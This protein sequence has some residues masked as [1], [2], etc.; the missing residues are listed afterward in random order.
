MITNSGIRKLSDPARCAVQLG[1]PLQRVFCA[2][3]HAAVEPRCL[4]GSLQPISV[5]IGVGR[6]LSGRRYLI[7]QKTGFT[8]GFGCFGLGP[9]RTNQ[10]LAADPHGKKKAIDSKPR[11]HL[12]FFFFCTQ[13][14][15][16]MTG[17]TAA[18]RR[19]LPSASSHV[20]MPGR[21][22]ASSVFGE[23]PGQDWPS[24]ILDPGGSHRGRRSQ[25]FTSN[26]PGDYCGSLCAN[27]DYSAGTAARAALLARLLPLDCSHCHALPSLLFTSRLCQLSP[28]VEAPRESGSTTVPSHF[29][30]HFSASHY[31]RLLDG[32]IL[33]M[34]SLSLS[35]SIGPIYSI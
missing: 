14:S 18:L 5:C 6:G 30:N 12:L 33:V 24:T 28:Y 15:L 7:N 21:T 34:S 1:I 19:C 16:H 8:C 23:S 26:T 10:P 3:C 11:A 20:V 4:C 35:E 13:W 31:P 27:A 32:W 29:A 25:F 22:L 2:V 17:K 9:R